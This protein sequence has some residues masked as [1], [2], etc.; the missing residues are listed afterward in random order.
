MK[1]PTSLKDL[2]VFSRIVGTA[3]L[4]CGYLLAGLYAGKW[5]TARG[6]PRWTL[7]LCLLAGLIAAALSC[8]HEVRS[9]L[10]M[11]RNNREDRQIRK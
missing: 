11:I 8:W 3:L 1:L 5:C 7:P 9:V 10:A 2:V 4:V 6:Y